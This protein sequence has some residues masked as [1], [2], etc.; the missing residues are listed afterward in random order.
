M[1]LWRLTLYPTLDGEG[2]RL[3]S[4]RWHTAGL[5][6][7]YLAASPAGALIEI[8]VHLELDEDE[9]PATYKL[10]RVRV[11]NTLKITS[12]RIPKGDL[13]KSDIDLTRSVG[14]RWLKS[15]SSAIAR[16]P[17]VL[18]PHTYNYLLNSLHPEAKRVRIVEV[19][20]AAIDTRLIR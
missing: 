16:V 11:P 12:P 2:G 19:Q 7:V 6:V 20:S 17:S 10:L 1:D 13:W 8:L 5:P 18:L 3:A 4:A 15:R 14:D 9:L